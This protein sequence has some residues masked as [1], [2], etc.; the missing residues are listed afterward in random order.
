M[1]SQLCP[2]LD[3]C[4]SLISS[5]CSTNWS[6]NKLSYTSLYTEYSPLITVSKGPATELCP[7]VGKFSPHPQV[8]PSTP[9]SPKC[10]FFSVYPINFSY[11]TLSV[12]GQKGLKIF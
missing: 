3:P 6:L 1:I 7:E 8:L 4:C 10:L 5:R 2:F 9:K 11:H 12:T